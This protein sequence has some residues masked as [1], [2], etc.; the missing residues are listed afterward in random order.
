MGV[1]EEDGEIYPSEIVRLWVSEGFLKPIDNKSLTKIAEQYLKELVDRNLI[2]VH[3]SKILGDVICYKIHD[4]LRDLSI[5]EAEKQRFFYVLREESPQGLISQQRIVIPTSTSEEKIQ[6]ALEYMPHARSY[7][8]FG[9]QTVGQ[10]SNSRFLRLLHSDNWNSEAEYSQ[11]NVFKLMN[12]RYHRFVIINKKFVIPSS[13]NLLWNLDTLIILGGGGLTAPTEIWKMYKLR[14]LEVYGLHIPDPSSADD[15]I[16]MMENLEVKIKLESLSL[17]SHSPDIGKYLQKINFPPSLK[18][19]F[20]ELESDLEWEDILQTIGSLP[21]LEKLVLY[22]RSLQKTTLDNGR[23]LPLS[24]SY[25]ASSFFVKRIEGDSSRNWRNTNTQILE[26][27]QD[28]HGD[29]LDLLVRV[30]V[31]KEDAALMQKLATSN[32]KVKVF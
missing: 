15:D 25:R 14:H 26:E 7:L 17:W 11:L 27:Q 30:K 20:L 28:L 29:Q 4:L 13:I 21:L 23:Q 12:S 31:L 9:N 6:D 24:T 22:E 19:L 8:V 32:F 5:K 2:L 18:E 10:F 16:I 3:E 1:F